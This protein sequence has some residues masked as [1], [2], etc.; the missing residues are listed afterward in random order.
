MGDSVESLILDV[1]KIMI[2]V[3]FGFDAGHEGKISFNP[4]RKHKY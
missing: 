3:F 2:S 1:V 4:W